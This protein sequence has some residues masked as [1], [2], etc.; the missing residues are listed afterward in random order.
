MTATYSHGSDVRTLLISAVLM[1]S[2]ISGRAQQQ[3]Q[4]LLDR[5][6]KPDMSLENAAQTKQFT[7]GGATVDKRVRTK[8][9]HVQNRRAEKQFVTGNFATKEFGTTK[10]RYQQQE[11]NVASR[12][13]VAKLNTPYPAPGFNGVRAAPENEKAVEASA[14]G[15]TRPFLGRGKS[16]KSLSAQDR[17]LTIDEVRELLNKNK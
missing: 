5:V 1:A 13:A 16:Q 6:L 17:P 14:Y 10:S 4:K 12:T 3:E 11:A 15:D 9:F 7:A 8:S 2:A